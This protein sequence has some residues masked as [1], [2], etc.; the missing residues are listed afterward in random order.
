MLFCSV[1]NNHVSEYQSIQEVF[2]RVAP[3]MV[4]GFE[5]NF[6][7]KEERSSSF[8]FR[9]HW[10]IVITF[11]PHQIKFKTLQD[12]RQCKLMVAKIYL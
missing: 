6:H 12:K 11:N 5:N 9:I 7:I 1:H 2:S 10:Q 4:N 8:L 3:M